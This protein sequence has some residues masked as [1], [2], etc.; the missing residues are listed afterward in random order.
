MKLKEKVDVVGL[1]T[2]MITVL[3]V[4]VAAFAAS[5]HECI[6]TSALDGNHGDDS[7]HYDGYAL[8]FRIKHLGKTKKDRKELVESVALHFG[9][10][11][12]ADYD[13]VIE[14]THIHVEYDPKIGGQRFFAMAS[15]AER[16]K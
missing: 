15:M 6:V 5:G 4:G 11:L 7:L 12:G 14:D 9:A 10:S 3:R 2:E 8:D 1:K 13:V 16:V